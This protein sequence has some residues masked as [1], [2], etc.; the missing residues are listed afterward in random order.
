MGR[1]FASLKYYN[2]RLW[3]ASSLVANTGSWMQR[4][5]QDWLVLAVLTHDDAFAVGLVTALQ[6]LPLLFLMS[7]AGIWADRFNKLK[8]LLI[9]QTLM[10]L[11]AFGLGIL[12]LL[13]YANVFYVCLFAVGLGVVA[14]FDNPP[15]QIF[16]SELVAPED[17]P[18]AVG[19]NSTSFNLARL[20]GP[21][22]AGILIAWTGPGWVFI[23][24]GISFIPTI[25]ALLAM[26]SS[27]FFP[28]VA[29]GAKSRSKG[30]LLEGLRYVRSRGDLMLIFIVTGTV[31]CLGMN[32]QITTAAVARLVFD[33]QAGEYGLLGSVLA[34][35]S[36]TGALLAARRRAQP[37]VRMVVG[38]AIGFAAAAG[39]NALMPT[40]P[41]YALSLIPVGLA[42]LTLLTCANTAVQMSTE[43]HMRGRVMGLYQTVMQGSAPL[44]SLIVGWICE[45]ISPRWGIGIG[46]IAAILAVICAYLWSRK[47]WHLDVSYHIHRP[48]IVIVGPREQQEIASHENAEDQLR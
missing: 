4:I 41:L 34:I 10:A 48:H 32:F 17:L 36:L 5:A 37:R 2:Y 19:L 44:G 9:T 14:A 8:I 45:D 29:G 16:V 46:S 21:G 33:K 23:I 38:G 31:A 47:R 26:R 3:F 39:I 13:G 7:I 43:S 35:G 40:Y 42:M 22:V 28:L 20:I 27:E 1:T 15:R 24:N 25:L 11:L 30:A 6:F 18:N 12:V